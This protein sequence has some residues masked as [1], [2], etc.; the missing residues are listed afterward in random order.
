MPKRL[1]DCGR[2][3]QC[4]GRW[5]VGFIGWSIAGGK[6]KNENPSQEHKI[7]YWQN[8]GIWDIF[9]RKAIVSQKLSHSR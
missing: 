3:G 5:V 2:G 9:K 7:P 8:K 1:V 4:G 6:S